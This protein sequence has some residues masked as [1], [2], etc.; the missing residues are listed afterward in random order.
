M[1]NK[2]GIQNKIIGIKMI[3]I[4]PPDV[5]SKNCTSKAKQIKEIKNKSVKL[6]LKI[7]ELLVFSNILKGINKNEA[8]IQEIGKNAIA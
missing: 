3:Y 2:I 7:F 4:A 1:K 6:S 5:K 8:M